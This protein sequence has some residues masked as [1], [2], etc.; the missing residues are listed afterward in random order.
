M[1]SLL[2]Y[3]LKLCLI[4][5][6]NLSVNEFLLQGHLRLSFELLFDALALIVSEA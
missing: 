2:V 1:Q 6:L 3:L 5:I 4:L